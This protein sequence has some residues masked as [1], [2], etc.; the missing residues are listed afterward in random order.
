MGGRLPRPVQ[1]DVRIRAARPEGKKDPV[2]T[3]PVR[4]KALPVFSQRKILRFRFRIQGVGRR[5]WR[6]NGYSRSPA[7]TIPGDAFERTGSGPA[8]P[9]PGCRAA[10]AGRKTGSEHRRPELRDI[11]LLATAHGSGR[12]RAHGGGYGSSIPGSARGR[13]QDPLAQRCTGWVVPFRRPG[14]QC[15]H[16]PCSGIDR[17]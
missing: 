10:P 17:K 6:T 7:G 8:N 16:L 12:Y 13:G 9:I 11:F 4:R 15:Y 14:F 1:W 3:R 2:R 5:R